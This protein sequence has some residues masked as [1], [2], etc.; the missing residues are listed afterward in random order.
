M[1]EILEAS[2]EVST[3]Q[4]RRTFLLHALVQQ[5]CPGM[6]IQP[7]GSASPAGSSEPVVV[8]ERTG[9][10]SQ[11]REEDQLVRSFMAG[12]KKALLA[13]AP[14]SGEKGTGRLTNAR[15]TLRRWPHF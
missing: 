4:A 2:G 5:W 10:L 14:R 7:V 1:D 11:Q 15:A 9:V 12:V 3:A 8:A 13:L 6:A